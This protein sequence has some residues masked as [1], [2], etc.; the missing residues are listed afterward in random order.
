M[1]R[2]SYDDAR[3]LL[4]AELKGYWDMPTFMAYQSDLRALHGKIR[5]RHGNYRFLAESAE[6]AV[7]SPE[8]GMAFEQLARDLNSS[9]KGPFAIVTRT[10]INKMQAQRV[11]PAPNLRVFMDRDEAIAWL[12]EEGRLPA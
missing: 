5:Q 1:F 11:L 4:T 3:R 10:R 6:F 9:N 8:V 2:L 12:F 7:Q